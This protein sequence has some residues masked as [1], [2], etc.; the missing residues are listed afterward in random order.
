M[1]GIWAAAGLSKRVLTLENTI[2][3]YQYLRDRLKFLRPSVA[4]LINQADGSGEFAD[5]K[6]LSACNERMKNGMN[7]P[8]S[9]TMSVHEYTDLLGREV[10]PVISG[11][12]NVLGKSDLESQISAIDHG[13]SMLETRLFNARE[14]TAKHKKLYQT[15]GVL[16]GLGLAVF[17]V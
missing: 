4:S 17:I 12:S 10:A 13:I 8:E 1:T 14:Y 16:A 9:W 11:L 6:F 3:L 7:F 5:L 15:L 2:R